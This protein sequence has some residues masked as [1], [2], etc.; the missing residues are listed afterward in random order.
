MIEQYLRFEKTTGQFYWINPPKRHPDL[1]NKEAGCSQKSRGNKNYWVIKLNGKKYKRGHLVYF[2]IHG[3]WPKPCLD[4]INGNS[5]DDRPENLRKA[6][7]TENN[8]NQKTRKRTINLP[9]GVRVTLRGERMW[10]FLDRLISISLPR[11]RDFRGVNDKSFDGRGNY[12]MGIT[13]QIIFPEIDI[14]KVN[15]IMGMDITMVTTAQTDA[16]AFALLK[17]IGIPFKK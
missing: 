8:W 9:I 5:L 7:I 4:H 3:E 15:K 14:E 13:E 17:E 10:E 11:V 2:L 16:E 1:L 6:T 12:T